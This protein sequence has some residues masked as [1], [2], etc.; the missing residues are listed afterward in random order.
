M[1]AKPVLHCTLYLTL[2]SAY[3][4]HF[5]SLNSSSFVVR[6]SYEVYIRQILTDCVHSSGLVDEKVIL[7]FAQF[8]AEAKCNAAA[9]QRRAPWTGGHQEDQTSTKEGESKGKCLVI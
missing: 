9:G 3:K 8:V 6:V 2:H 4:V 5:L 1:I 7:L